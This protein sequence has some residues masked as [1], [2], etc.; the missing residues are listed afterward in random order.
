MLES[1]TPRIVIE[2]ACKAASLTGIVAIVAIKFDALPC[3]SSLARIY[4]NL[5]ENVG[6]QSSCGAHRHTRTLSL[7][8][9]G[10]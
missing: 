8:R 7:L 9:T 4:Y 1:Q 3:Q 5:H 2:L 6:N 10:Q